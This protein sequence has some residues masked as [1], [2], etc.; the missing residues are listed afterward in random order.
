MKQK[1]KERIKKIPSSPGVYIFKDQ[2]GLVIY[3]GKAISLSKRV[4]SYFISSLTKGVKTQKLVSQIDKIDFIV[5]ESEIE[6]LILEAEL[7]KK[8]QPRYNLKLK[9]DKSFLYVVI[10]DD[11][12]PRIYSARK[13]EG[14]YGPFPSASIVKQILRLVRPIF[15]FC[16]CRRKR[17]K[18]CLYEDLK[19]CPG[20]SLNADEISNYK[21]SMGKLKNLFEGKSQKLVK[22]TGKQMQMAS[23]KNEFE[24]AA[25][26]R[27]QLYRLEYLIKTRH[28]VRDYIE[29]PNLIEDIREKEVSDLINSVSDYYKNFPPV[30]NRLE[31]FDI[32]NISGKKATGSMV[33]FVNGEADKS[34][35]RKFQIRM[36]NKPNDT[37]MMKEI[38]RRRVNH[39]EWEFPDLILVDGGKGQVSAGVQA[40]HEAG[41]KIPVIGLAKREEILVIPTKSAKE[42]FKLLRLQGNSPA[43]NLLKRIRDEAHRFA[44]SYH[45][46]LRLIPGSV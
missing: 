12:I 40:V 34:S 7:V 23:K 31:A 3:V 5:V 26:L 28:P 27:D 44:L 14:G 13:T 1:L 18:H 19:L 30:I 39:Q 22:E 45:R 20:V 35:Y 29:N 17:R 24:K 33:V 42:N 10:T 32:S 8:Y 15:P 25:V 43:L 46:R 6:A 21:S 38:I 37:A 9:D 16:S 36:E 4:K 41:F 2:E 11:E